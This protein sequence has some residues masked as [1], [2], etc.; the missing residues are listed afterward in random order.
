MKQSRKVCVLAFV[1]A[2]IIGMPCLAQDVEPP[3]KW[4]GKGAGTFISEY[5]TQDLE[6]QFEM[7]V[8]EYGMVEGRTINEDGTSALKHV[9]Y[10]DA[11][12]HDFPGFFSRRMVFVFM[13]NEYGSN[14][15]LAVLNAR[16]LMDKFMYGEVL[17]TRYEAGSDM[18]R[19]L[20]VGDSEATLMYGEELPSDLKAALKKCMPFGTAKVVGDYKK[21]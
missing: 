18:A 17:M 11:K 13:I 8:D 9:F 6:F 2:V 15:M 21:D 10:S 5:G 20:G 12:E 14:P 1:A 7:S 4:V 3:F 19:T 16:V